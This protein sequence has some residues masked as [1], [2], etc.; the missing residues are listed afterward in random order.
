MIYRS[1]QGERDRTYSHNGSH[2]TRIV[3]REELGGE[4]PCLEPCYDDRPQFLGITMPTHMAPLEIIE[5]LRPA[6]QGRTMPFLCRAEDDQLY[7]VKGKSAGV[8]GQFCEWVVAHLAKSFGLPIPPFCQV[9]VPEELLAESPPSHQALGAGIAFASLART[10][11]QWFEN[12]FVSEVPQDLRR[13]VLAFDW[14]VR[15]SDRIFDNPNLLWSPGSK[16][17]VVIDHAFAFDD[18]FWPTIFLQY[19]V[20]RDDWES[21]VSDPAQQKVYKDKML[22]AIEEWAD[23]CESGHTVWSVKG[24]GDAEELLDCAAALAILEGCKKDNP[25]TLN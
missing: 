21:I 22:T 18:D 8:R 14:W 15:N 1:Q 5:I 11:A 9:R 17:L 10:Q 16:E 12:S 2:V 25:W 20:F 23:A 19:H 7:Y 3:S 4:G 24:A 6:E 13:A